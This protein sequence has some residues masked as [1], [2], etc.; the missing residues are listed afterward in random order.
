VSA[1]GMGRQGP[2]AP[3]RPVS[4]TS[5]RQKSTSKFW[6]EDLRRRQPLLH[7]RAIERSLAYASAAALGRST[8]G[9]WH[10]ILI[11]YN[12]LSIHSVKASIA[13]AATSGFNK[14][15]CVPAF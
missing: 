11:T 3:K 14:M 9:L 5:S 13:T 12:A 2:T 15:P 7:D 6:I 10:Q 4:A 8:M 1:V